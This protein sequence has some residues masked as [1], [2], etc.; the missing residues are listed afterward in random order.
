MA[1]P[2]IRLMLGEK[3][4]DKHVIWLDENYCQAHRHKYLEHFNCYLK[5]HP[6][7]TITEKVGFLDIE[8]TGLE[9]DWDIMTC[10]VIK[11]AKTKNLIEGLITKKEISNWE[12]LDSRLMAQ[13]VS[14]ASKWDR[15]IMHY[16]SRFDVPFARTRALYWDIGFPKHKSVWQTDTW[17]ISRD[18]LRMSHNR[19]ENLGR[20]IHCPIEKTKLN[21]E[22][23]WQVLTGD[24]KGFDYIIDH[25]RKD[26][27]MLEKVYNKLK[28]SVA[29][30]NV[31]I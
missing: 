5:E 7:G 8:T 9:A 25:C 17:R 13:F 23:K 15:L 20:L 29:L 22:R 14:D 2:R 24:K 19:L 10:Y 3:D 16:G 27:L 4:G 26:V 6:C 21:F 30:G 11:P 1:R 31:S 28:D 18:K 12:V